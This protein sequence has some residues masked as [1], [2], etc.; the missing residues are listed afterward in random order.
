MPLKINNQIVY[1]NPLDITSV[2]SLDHDVIITTKE[3]TYTVKDSLKNFCQKM[4]NSLLY[5]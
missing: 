2:I 5:K 3:K 1:I 4:K